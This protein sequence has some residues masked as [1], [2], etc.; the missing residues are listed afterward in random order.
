MTITPPPRPT[1]DADL[2]RAL[3]GP[4]RPHLPTSPGWYDPIPEAQRCLRL[5]VDALW[6]MPNPNDG[7]AER[8]LDWAY[9]SRQRAQQT[10]I[11]LP[12]D[13]TAPTRPPRAVVAFGLPFRRTGDRLVDTYQPNQT[14]LVSLRDELLSSI[15]SVGC[16]DAR[17]T[18]TLVRDLVRCLNTYITET[19]FG[20]AAGYLDQPCD[21]PYGPDITLEQLLNYSAAQDN[22]PDGDAAGQADTAEQ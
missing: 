4:T 21:N 3:Y 13:R 14:R 15:D 12:E 19:E 20:D 9:T 8:H 22:P 7:P 5:L 16:E 2:D 17:D 10:L 6:Q 1:P 18:A 11:V